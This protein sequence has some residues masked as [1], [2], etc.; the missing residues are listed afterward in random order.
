VHRSRIL[1]RWLLEILVALWRE[2]YPD[3]V[4]Q[5]QLPIE[6]S[7]APPS[8]AGWQTFSGFPARIVAGQLSEDAS[9]GGGKYYRVFFPDPAQYHFGWA[10]SDGGQE[11]ARVG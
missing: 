2:W 4:E 1:G 10:T 5:L 7:A 11:G 9:E 6:L 3:S 8:G